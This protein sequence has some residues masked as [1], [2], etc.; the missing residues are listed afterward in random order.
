TEAGNP[1]QG[2][3]K[4][5]RVDPVT[6]RAKII[7]EGSVPISQSAR[8]VEVMRADGEP[9]MAV[10]LETAP[11]GYERFVAELSETLAQSSLLEVTD[12]AAN[13]RALIRIVFHN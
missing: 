11:P 13:A 1:P 7:E 6:A 9:K 12:S 5:S 10:W 4:I 2:L 3:V 8:A